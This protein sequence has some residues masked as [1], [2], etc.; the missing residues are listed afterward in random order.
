MPIVFCGRASEE[1]QESWSL[2]SF[3]TLEILQVITIS[4]KTEPPCDVKVSIMSEA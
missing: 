4:N 2:V 3:E 1:T